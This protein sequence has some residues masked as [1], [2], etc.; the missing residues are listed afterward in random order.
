MSD[1]LSELEQKASRLS[2]EERAQF[3]LFLLGTLE[4]TEPGNHED[5]WRQ[6]AEARLLQI[7]RGEAQ[8]V[9]AADVFDRLQRRVN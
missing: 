6:E 8:L 1:D 2:A 3:A 9:P 7:E 5:I 4:S